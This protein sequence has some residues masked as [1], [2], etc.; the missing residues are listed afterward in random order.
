MDYY[1]E[2]ALNKIKHDVEEC[3]ALKEAWEKVERFKTKDGADFKILQKN[4]SAKISKQDYSGDL[5]ISVTRNK[6]GRY[7]SDYIPVSVTVQDKGEAEEYRK[8]GRLVERGAYLYPYINR[9]P[10]EIEK[11]IE[12]RI[13][14]Y[15]GRI[16]K[17]KKVLGDFD[18]IAGK[19]VALRE[20]AKAFI[21]EQS[22]AEYY[23]RDILRETQ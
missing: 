5:K 2:I 16:E 1:A 15:E 6:N 7:Y 14:Y 22:C 13:K 8:Q 21:K 9:T 12:K 11:E 19:I 23:L 17:L 4:F 10:D 20:E 18:N 3:E